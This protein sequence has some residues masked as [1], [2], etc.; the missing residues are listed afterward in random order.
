RQEND[1]PR[2]ENQQFA[3]NENPHQK[4]AGQI[5]QCS[6]GLI[7]HSARPL[8]EPSARHDSIGFNLRRHDLSLHYLNAHCKY[9]LPHTR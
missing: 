2:P 5:V 8:Q 3:D 6:S 1:Q 7:R 4:I 9:Q